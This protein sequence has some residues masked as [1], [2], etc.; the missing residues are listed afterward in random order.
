MVVSGLPTVE[1]W[2]II[3]MTTEKHGM[4]REPFD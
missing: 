4:A 2:G 3:P 1:V